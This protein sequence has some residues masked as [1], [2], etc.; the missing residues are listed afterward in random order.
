MIGRDGRGLPVGL[1]ATVEVQCYGMIAGV[2]MNG[3]G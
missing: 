1:I 2:G 3:Y